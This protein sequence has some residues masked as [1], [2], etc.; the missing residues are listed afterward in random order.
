MKNNKS[1]FPAAVIIMVIAFFAIVF[2]ISKKPPAKQE[3]P[4][5]VPPSYK[6]K[7]AIVIDDWGYNLYN[8]PLAEK[9]KYPFTAAVLPNLKNSK[10]ASSRLNASG[11]EVILHL[12][13]EPKEKLR[14]ENNTIKTGSTKEEI[15]RIVKNDLES[16]VYAKGVSNHMGSNLTE[17]KPAMSVILKELKKRKL[18]FLDSF[19][20]GGS[21]AKELSAK[22][23]VAFIKRDIFLDNKADKNYIRQQLAKLKSYAKR[24]G[25]A[26]GIGH[27]RK[28]TLETLIEEM[29]KLSK[30]GYKLVFVSELAR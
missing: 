5:F 14:L 2:L 17:N 7:I 30:E 3:K 13:M 26:V 15:E 11:F 27:D 25:Y 21:V 16:I 23:G 4:A 29:P 20:T 24:Q 12:P 8:F 22:Y 1:K 9:I 18:Y 10:E 6:G 28:T 19:V